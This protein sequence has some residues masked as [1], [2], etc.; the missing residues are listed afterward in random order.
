[1]LVA[2]GRGSSFLSWNIPVFC[3]LLVRL[4][5]IQAAIF[6]VDVA[7]PVAALNCNGISVSPPLIAMPKINPHATGKTA[8]LPT[9]PLGS[10][11][12]TLR[13]MNLRLTHVVYFFY[14]AIH[15]F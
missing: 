11:D 3:C 8:A 5:V 7:Y 10:Y 4:T 14:D 1:M 13:L 6:Q 2:H 12:L 15:F 9:R